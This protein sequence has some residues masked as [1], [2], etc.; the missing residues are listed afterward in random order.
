MP[1]LAIR[2]RDRIARFVVAEQEPQRQALRMVM[3]DKSLPLMLRLKAQLELQ[4]FSRYARP[5]ALHSRCIESGKSRGYIGEFK[6]SKI[7]FREKAL[8]GELPGVRKAL[9]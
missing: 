4:K 5:S 3:K 7:V 2:L 1:A 9:W 6:L 8:A